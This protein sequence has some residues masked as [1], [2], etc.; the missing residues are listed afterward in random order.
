MHLNDLRVK[1]VNK[2]W[3]GSHYPFLAHKPHPLYSQPNPNLKLSWPYD[4][5]DSLGDSPKEEE[6]RI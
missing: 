4:N 3:W 2:I 6:V 5:S 1:P